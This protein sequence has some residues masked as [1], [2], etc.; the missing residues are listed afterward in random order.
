MRRGILSLIILISGCDT[1]R[2]NP[3]AEF[4]ASCGI[5][6]ATV[7]SLTLLNENGKLS[8]KDIELSDQ[9]IKRGQAILHLWHSKLTLKEDTSQVQSEMTKVN[10]ELMEI[11]LRGGR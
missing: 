9:L 8:D 6:T 10:R 11:E 4:V 2:T 7:E 1:I 5:F 3:R